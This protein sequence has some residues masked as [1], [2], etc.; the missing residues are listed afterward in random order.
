M[1]SSS[2]RTSSFQCAL[3]QDIVRVTTLGRYQLSRLTGIMLILDFRD[4][5]HLQDVLSSL[6]IE[7]PYKVK[8]NSVGFEFPF[9]KMSNPL[10]KMST[11]ILCS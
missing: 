11:F 10:M 9:M 2:G 4:T 1:W 6:N 7:R 8:E 5:V 3:Y